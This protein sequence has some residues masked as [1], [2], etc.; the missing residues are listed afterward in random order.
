MNSSDVINFLE[1]KITAID[2]S[3]VNGSYLC[4]AYGVVL[5]DLRKEME[6]TLPA[7]TPVESN[8]SCLHYM[9]AYTDGSCKGN[10]GPGGYAVVLT[11]DPHKS[12][13]DLSL[14]ERLQSR[15]HDD[16]TNN[17]ME[18]QAV[19]SAMSMAF[20]NHASKPFK[21][22]IIESDSRYA[23]DGK[24]KYLEGWKKRGWKKADKT[25]IKNIDLWQEFDRVLEESKEHFVTTLVWVKGHDGNKWNEFVDELAQK[26]ADGVYIK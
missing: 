23:V 9:H 7:P 6:E 16:T 13:H 10:P 14:N 12:I 17:R 5:N 11:D 3:D 20:V 1:N 15:Q 4:S 8:E 24:T 19:I 21:E 26:A 22:L 2:C 25:P 18:L